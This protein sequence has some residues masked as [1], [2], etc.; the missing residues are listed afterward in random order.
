MCTKLENQITEIK[1]KCLREIFL[2][3]FP[4]VKLGEEA[5]G[6]ERLWKGEKK[7]LNM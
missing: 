3:S 4:I 1:K 6:L 7:K 5:D 2:F